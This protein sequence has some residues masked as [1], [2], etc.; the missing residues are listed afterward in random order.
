[1]KVVR[2]GEHGD[3]DSPEISRSHKALTRELEIPVVALLQLNGQPE[4]CF[5]LDIKQTGMPNVM[6]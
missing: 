3:L 4:L 6:L 2:T 1:M 5:K